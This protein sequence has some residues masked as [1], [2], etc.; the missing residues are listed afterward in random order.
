[1]LRETSGQHI[2]HKN[3]Q[4][5]PIFQFFINQ[6]F[7]V[8]IYEENTAN[9]QN[10]AGREFF[11]GVQPVVRV[12]PQLTAHNWQKWKSRFLTCHCH[13]IYRE[14]MVGLKSSNYT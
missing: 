6:T 7:L 13:E 2:H 14:E 9:L 10:R 1:M 12:L 8:N 4:A 5:K 3:K 11:G